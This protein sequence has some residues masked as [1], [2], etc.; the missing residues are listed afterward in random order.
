M[1]PASNSLNFAE[2]VENELMKCISKK[3]TNIFCP[4]FSVQFIAAYCKYFKGL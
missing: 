1:F 4:I 2:L 3:I